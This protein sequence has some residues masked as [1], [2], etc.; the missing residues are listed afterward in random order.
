MNE[1]YIHLNTQE[2]PFTIEELRAKNLAASTPIWYE[3][4]NDWSTVG[5]IPE[6]RSIVKA[7]PPPF[8]SA[9]QEDYQYQIEMEELFPEKK[10]VSWGAVLLVALLVTLF[11]CLVWVMN[12]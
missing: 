9:A 1:Y 12:Q 7:T 3:G 6:L 4:L 5:Q 10:R 11:T 8:R 2:G